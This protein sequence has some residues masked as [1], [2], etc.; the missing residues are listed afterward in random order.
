M[1]THHHNAVSETLAKVFKTESLSSFGLPD[2]MGFV[3]PR[4]YFCHGLLTPLARR[5]GWEEEVSK[6]KWYHESLLRQVEASTPML[7][8]Q[9][10]DEQAWHEKVEEEEQQIMVSWS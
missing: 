9:F 2:E 1:F 4:N 10:R 3:W 5:Q 8:E 6:L 7:E